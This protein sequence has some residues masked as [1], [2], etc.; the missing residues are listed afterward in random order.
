[1]SEIR[2]ARSG[3][4]GD[5]LPEVRLVLVHERSQPCVSGSSPLR[6]SKNVRRMASVTGRLPLPIAILSIERIGVTSTAVPQKKA[7]SAR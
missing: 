5:A 6:M 2:L 1:M 3:R 7:S 4:R